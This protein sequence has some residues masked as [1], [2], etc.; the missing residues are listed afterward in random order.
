M[1]SEI[2]ENIVRE[3]C[4]LHTLWTASLWKRFNT[5]V[6]QFQRSGLSQVSGEDNDKDNDKAE[7]EKQHKLIRL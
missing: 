6:D 5:D 1:R 7:K 4:A 3:Y 2:R